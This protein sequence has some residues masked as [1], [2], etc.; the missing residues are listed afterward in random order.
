MGRWSGAVLGLLAVSA[1][2]APV[3]RSADDAGTIYL[4][5]IADQD[6]GRPLAS[7]D[8]DGDGY[9]EVIVAASESWGGVLSRVYV[10]R[11][12]PDAHR[13]GTMDL[14]VGG[15]DQ[16]ILGA[17]VD[18]NLGC[19]IATG[20]VNGDQIDDLLLCASTADFSGLTDAGIAYLIYGGP[21]F[22]A[23]STR[24]LSDPA[25]EWDVRFGGPVS[26]G[27]MGGA[28][29]F[30][31]VDTH[32]AAIGRLN[33]DGYGDV[34]LGVHLATGSASTAG[35]VYVV[36]GQ[37]FASGTTLSLSAAASFHVLVYGDDQDDELG[38]YVLTGDLTG[39]GID[40]LILPNRNYSQ[41]LFDT[42]G[43]VHIYR[44]TDSWTKYNYLASTLAP[45]TLL[46]YRAYDELGEAAAVGDFNGDGIVDLAAAA[47]GAELGAHTIQRGDGFVYGL[48]GSTA[49][50][51][52][53]FVI[54]YATAT[55]DFLLIGEP[56]ENLGQQT[57][58]GDFNGDGY[59]DIA[60]AEWFAGPETNG[61]VEVLFGRDFTGNPTFTANVDTDVHFLG[62]PQDRISFS[63]SAGDVD[64]NGVDEVLFG[65]PFNNGEYPDEAGTVYVFTLVDGDSD[66]DGDVDLYDY[67]KLQYCFFL[68]APPTQ[69]DECYVFD[70]E[71]DGTLDLADYAEFA[72]RVTGPS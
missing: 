64:S 55:P 48:L 15:V 21:N 38:E 61:A 42:E 49:Y 47:P 57:S 33:S 19:S 44:G 8:L 35:R 12:G 16:V 62:A 2:A 54:D 9:D 65:T 27:D 67:A 18:D 40:E 71:A 23:S 52:G 59:D 43:A 11:G 36:M 14:M 5:A 17:G 45:I 51:T 28:N 4:G 69:H 10:V 32:A 7:G 39:D 53:T 1:M 25:A 58:A 22:F 34:V 20:D 50:Q 63:L 56:E 31:G 68:P 72:E 26:Y 60:A 13:R 29:A 30:G 3:Q 70:L 66:G 41:Y 24:D 37:A 6:W 46:G